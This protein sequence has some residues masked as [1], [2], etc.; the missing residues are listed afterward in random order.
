MFLEKTHTGTFIASCD[1]DQSEILANVFSSV[2]TEEDVNNL[3][4]MNIRK[5]TTKSPGP[6]RAHP[7]ILFELS[8]VIDKPLYLIFKN[9]FERGIVPDSST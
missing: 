5:N 9:S 2:L 3:P 7:K 8:S 1:R 6:D 4:K